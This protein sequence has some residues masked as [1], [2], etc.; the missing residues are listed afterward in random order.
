MHI[1]RGTNTVACA[2]KIIQ[3]R[4]PER[5]AREGVDGHAWSIGV[6]GGWREVSGICEGEVR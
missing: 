3:A 2:V 4:L 5:G 1:Q 6:V